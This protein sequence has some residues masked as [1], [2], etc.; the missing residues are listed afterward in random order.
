MR[1]GNQASTNLPQRRQPLGSLNPLLIRSTH[2]VPYTG[3]IC[4]DIDLR[5]LLIA[6]GYL[7]RRPM[8]FFAITTLSKNTTFVFCFVHRSVT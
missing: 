7:P 1:Y 2:S 8:Y 5:G 4:N 6:H 3:H